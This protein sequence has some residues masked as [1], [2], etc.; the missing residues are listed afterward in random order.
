MTIHH[1]I[2]SIY[3][4]RV[5][6]H[7][8]NQLIIITIIAFTIIR[9]CHV[10]MIPGCFIIHIILIAIIRRFIISIHRVKIIDH[11]AGFCLNIDNII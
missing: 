8:I 3:E 2:P 7:L 6:D 4:D 10:I 5:V 1:I 9:Y 11:F